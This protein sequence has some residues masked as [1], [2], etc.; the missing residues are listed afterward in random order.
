MKLNE[1]VFFRKYGDYT[2][3]RYTDRQTDY[4]F[5]AAAYD[6]LKFI[7]RCGDC[8]VVELCEYLE[9]I[10][11]IGDME[12]FLCDIK[13]FINELADDE[14]IRLDNND[15]EDG[16]VETI[17]QYCAENHILHSVCLE[18]TY[19]CNEKCI[20]CYIDDKTDQTKE[21]NFEEYKKLLDE[22][23]EMGCISLLLTGGEVTLRKDFF[24][25]AEY[26]VKKGFAVN[27]YTNGYSLTDDE[28]RS[29][30][31][32]HLNSLSFSFYGGA[33]ETHDKITQVKGSF[34]RSLQSLIKCK[35]LGIETYIKTVVMKQNINTYEQLFTL[36]KRYGVKVAASLAIAHT[37]GGRSADD[38]RLLDEELYAKALET[39]WKYQPIDFEKSFVSRTAPGLCGA[40]ITALSVDPYGNVAP[41]NAYPANLG[42]IRSQSIREIW[43]NNEF[44]KR[45][46]VLEFSDICD[47]YNECE[48]THRCSI[49]PGNLYREHNGRF[50]P[51]NDTCKIAYATQKAADSMVLYSKKGGGF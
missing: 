14:I 27:V 11:E 48:N 32:M 2:Y 26:A 22:I 8:S 13:N 46:A 29:F 39:E 34:E 16:A 9:S 1:G 21:L 18:L 17:R 28:I 42:N 23:Y 20:H 7:Q 24:E 12:A 38:F 3:L 43:E 30:S 41:C 40:G 37:H 35:C 6:I 36:A 5:N 49:C 45:L 31:E 4:L 15:S 50:L 25:I 47:K 19:R 51:G 33:A 10:Y 44:L